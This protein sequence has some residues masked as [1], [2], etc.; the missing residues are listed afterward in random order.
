MSLEDPD[1]DFPPDP[2]AVRAPPAARWRRVLPWRGGPALLA[3]VCLAVFAAQRIAGRADVLTGYSF[4]DVLTF[5]FGLHGPLL[6]RG[7]FWQ[8][9]TYL[10]L[11]GS[12]L[13]LAMNTV[14]VLFFGGAL[15]EELGRRRF[16]GL[17][18]VTGVLGGLGWLALDAAE[19]GLAR[20]L[21]SAS[22]PGAAELAHRLTAA[23]AGGRFGVCIGASAA[24]FGLIGAY[25]AL[26]PRRR[27]VVLLGWPVQ[28]RARTLA[29]LLGAVTVAEMLLHRG[30]VAYAAHLAGG[31]AG[32]FVG[33]RLRRGGLGDAAESD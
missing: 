12:L 19:P 31:V 1:A 18:F 8:P 25:A 13:H 24:V 5:A 9:L 10:F 2:G 26:F 7:F 16:Y 14:T 30:Q 3:G 33:R 29:L 17:F 23:H 27:V 15:E 11:H 4:A 20:L 22:W 32:Y 6:A 28:M 21:E